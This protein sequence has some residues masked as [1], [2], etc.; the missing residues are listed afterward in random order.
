MTD[1]KTLV[2]AVE[3]VVKSRTTQ[4]EEDFSDQDV[5]DRMSVADAFCC[6]DAISRGGLEA[7]GFEPHE[8]GGEG[9]WIIIGNVKITWNGPFDDTSQ[10]V[11]SHW[12]MES[13]GFIDARRGCY[14]VP[15]L[16]TIG[17]LLHLLWRLTRPET[18]A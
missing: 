1:L 15:Y 16:R 2:E 9:L 8:G 17:D 13:D 5:R 18:Q 12:P 7:L 3:R 11:F 10:H 6:Q 4:I 14:I